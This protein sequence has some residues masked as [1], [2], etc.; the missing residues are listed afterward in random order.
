[1]I[2]G[3]ALQEV[4]VGT[5]GTAGTASTASA[6]QWLAALPVLAL[7]VAVVL[8]P[9]LA[10]GWALRLRGVLLVTAAPALTVAVLGA[11]SLATPL[12]GVRWGLGPLAAGT[13]LA[14]GAAALAGRLAPRLLR[15]RLPAPV[16]APP[17]ARAVAAL[18]AGTAV[19]TALAVATAVRGLGRPDVVSQAFDTIFHLNAVRRVLDTGSASPFDVAG[20]TSPQSGGFYPSAWHGLAALVAGPTS[21]VLASNAL[22]AVVPGVV[23]A[24]SAGLL[25][26]AVLGPRP[27]PLLLA[28][29]LAQG[30]VAFPWYV[31]RG[32][33]WPFVLGTALVPAVLGGL[34]LAAGGRGEP[35]PPVPGERPRA[36]VVAA[37]AAAGCA[38]AHPGAFFVVL[39]LT[40]VLAVVSVLPALLLPWGGARQHGVVLLVAALT[41]LV[42]AGAVVVAWPSLRGMATADWPATRSVARAVAEALRGAPASSGAGWLV[43][44]LVLLG[45]VRACTRVRWRWLAVGHVVVAALDVLAASVDSPLSSALTA[46]WYNDR[47]RLA[48]SLPVTGTALAVLGTCWA[49]AAAARAARTPARARRAA[50]VVAVLVALGAAVPQVRGNAAQLAKSNVDAAEHPRNSLVTLAEQRFLEQ[51]DRYV[52]EGDVVAGTPWDGS[53]FAYALSGVEVLYPHLRGDYPDDWVFLADHLQD[54]GVDPAVCPVLE[55]HRVRWVLDDG[56][57]WRPPRLEPAGYTAFRAFQGRPGFEPVASGGGAVLYRITACG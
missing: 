22:V 14:A 13:L 49:G 36:L 12:A 5:A 10:V 30:F 57:L 7:A 21:P 25:V 46:P 17:Q 42:A 28:P 41:V 35:G 15:R 4:A 52:P 40:A 8:A 3:T 24:L 39:L 47:G 23:W 37:A 54:A 50:G 6:G 48:A 45:A 20:L 29:V 26:R 1:M 43:G 34:A 16:P 11:C 44:A 31:D 53:G 38:L 32:G 19:A 56:P 18:L 2:T 27:L 33:L 9:G 55:R 51:L